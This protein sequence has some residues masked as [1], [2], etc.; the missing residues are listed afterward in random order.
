MIS[1]CLDLKRARKQEPPQLSYYKREMILDR[2]CR[3]SSA[4]DEHRDTNLLIL[5]YS[6]PV[7]PL[8]STCWTEVVSHT[9]NKAYP[10]P[11]DTVFR[12]LRFQH[13]RRIVVC[14]TSCR[15]ES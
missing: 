5:M 9:E 1:L 3:S 8:N 13:D 4:L 15:E 11:R 14:Q 2:W 10:Q 7:P 6:H 12:P